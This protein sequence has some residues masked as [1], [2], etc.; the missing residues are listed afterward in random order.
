MIFLHELWA[1]KAI[2]ED[3]F[4]AKSG[5]TGILNCLLITVDGIMDDTQKIIRHYFSIDM[6]QHYG[7]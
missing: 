6:I 4:L 1:S 3:L 2:L 5:L 7:H